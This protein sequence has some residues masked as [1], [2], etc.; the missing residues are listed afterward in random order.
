[1]HS[2]R[3]TWRTV[4]RRAGVPEDRIRE[5]GGWEGNRDTADSYDHGLR[6]EDLKQVQLGIWNGLLEQGYLE[7]F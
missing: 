6:D 4:A 5:L 2:F 1:M 7:Q 3:H